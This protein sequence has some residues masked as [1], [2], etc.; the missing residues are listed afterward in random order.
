MTIPLSSIATLVLG[1]PQTAPDAT[2][3]TLTIWDF[4]IK[5]GPTMILIAACSLVALAVIVERLILTRRR[6]VAPADLAA[7]VKAAAADPARALD[8]CKASKSALAP[9]LATAIRHRAEPEDFIKK[10]VS[11]TGKREIA[12]LRHRMRLLSALPQVATMLGLFGTILG[13]IKTFQAVA[14]SG[15]SLGKTELLARGIFEAW[16][17]TAAGLLVAIPT[18]IMYHVLQGRIDA[19]IADLDRIATDFIEEPRNVPLSVT[20]LP[21]AA[22]A[23]SD[24]ATT[25]PVPATA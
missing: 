18:L 10:A 4:V 21:A 6:A 22:S 19:R 5:G 14:Q 7:N 8:L 12:R 13:M 11:D 15:Q 20:T 23:A 1:A 17:C 25:Q 9:I 3:A 16:A 2:P 24:I